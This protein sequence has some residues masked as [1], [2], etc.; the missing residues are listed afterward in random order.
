[1]SQVNI[2]DNKQF[3]GYVNDI[4]PS[5][6]KVHFPSSVLLNKYFQDGAGL[7]SGI[8]G[9][10]VLV[11][12]EDHGFLAKVMEIS[13]PEKERLELTQDAFRSKEFHP[14]GKLELLLCFDYRSHHCTKGF[15]Q[16]P[17]VGSKIYSCPDQFLSAILKDF[18][19]GKDET[20][21]FD[22]AMLPTNSATDVHISGQSLLSRHCAIVGS[23]GG[24]KS[25]TVAKT[26]EQIMRHNGKAILIDATGEYARFKEFYNEQVVRQ[27]F[28]SKDEDNTFFH[29]TSLKET[30]LI[31]MFRPS[32]QAQLPKLQEALKSLR[33]VKILEAK[34]GLT[35]NDETIK[36]FF[37]ARD[38]LD[39]R[40]L[41]KDSKPRKNFLV[42]FKDND[43]VFKY[44]C[45][46]NINALP[47]QVMKECISDFSNSENFG[48]ENQTQLGHCQSL[49]SRMLLTLNNSDFKAVFGFEQQDGSKGLEKNINDFLA[50]RKQHLLII[51]TH[52]VPSDNSMRDILVNSI[53]RFLLEKALTEELKK[54]PLILILDEAHQFLNKKI[55]DEYSVEVD[56]NA[57]ERIA[58]ECRKFGLFLVIATQMPRDIPSGVLSQMGAFIVHRLINQKDREAIEYA[59]SDANANALAFLPA[60]SAGEALIT[61]V[62]FPMPIILKIK[63]PNCKPDSSTP[64]L[65][66]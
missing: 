38:G 54:S 31:A 36:T 10:Y 14:T 11:E 40:T 15:N 61:G 1:M 49:I 21:L 56:L 65:F 60:L 5:Y 34:A 32:G 35:K 12:G 47:R 3:I 45:D 16:F 57:F 41:S 27:V 44:T 13:L 55:K 25:W 22:M 19:K 66:K 37:E 9:N 23:T 8:V 42:A 43:A 50:N 39:Y 2:F 29:Y 64:P 18:G 52:L 30:D 20:K 46:I 62:E 59:C 24:G 53:G 48:A 4:N 26:I 28:N 7:H 33:L 58:K 63:A 17:A 51:D 6:I